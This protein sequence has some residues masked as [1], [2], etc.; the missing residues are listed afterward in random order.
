MISQDSE[1]QEF[2]AMQAGTWYDVERCAYHAN[3][4][5]G[6]TPTPR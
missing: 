6:I 4:N 2:V 3:K 5:H 1:L